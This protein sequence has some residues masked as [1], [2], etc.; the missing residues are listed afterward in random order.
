MSNTNT[1]EMNNDTGSPLYTSL[2][3]S[4]AA[5]GG[6]LFGFDWAVIAGAT[7]YIKKY[8]A[9]EEHPYLFGAAISSALFGCIF[10]A[11]FAG[12]LSDRFGRRKVLIGAAI[13]FG[14]AGV[15]TAIPKELWL[16]IVARMIGGVAIGLSSPVA[17]MYIAE[18]SP[19]KNRGALV[20]LNQLAIT[21]GIVM[22]YA[23]DWFI[24]GVGS[25]KWAMF[26]GLQSVIPGFGTEGWGVMYAWRWMF[27]ALSIPAVLFLITLMFV[28]E[29]PRW[30]AK[31]GRL[32]EAR[33]ILARVGGSRH[34]DNEMNEIQNALAQEEA[35][36]WQLFQPGL[37]MAL[38]IGLMV[39]IMSQIT[40]NF[41]VFTYTLSLMKE[42]GYNNTNINML[43]MVGLGMVNFLATIVAIAVLDK[44]GRRPI[45]IVT[46][47]GMSAC[48]ALVAANSTWELLPPVALV[49]GIMAFVVFYALGVGPVSWLVVSEVFPTKVRGRAMSVCT[50]CLW[51]TN[52][53]MTLLFPRAMALSPAGTFWFFAFTSFLLAVFTWAILPETKGLPLEAIEKLW[54]KK[55]D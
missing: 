2:I 40:G 50:F 27:A 46:A 14:I 28:P 10:G 9:L 44:L 30:L 20:T 43:L 3:A 52:F 49:A 53:L 7:E 34:A 37:G 26:P 12:M 24:D 29:S 16:F 47:L 19:E 22:A 54:V 32:K 17:P 39:M 25:T 11:S 55:A 4:V 6:L 41:A 51:S 38:V 45:L 21:F 18:I 31:V 36:L 33:A 1:I 8:F 5:L 42:L 35:S 13:L 48:M 15:L 23:C